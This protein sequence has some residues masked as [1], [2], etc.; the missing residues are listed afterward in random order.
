MRGSLEKPFLVKSVSPDL[1]PKTSNCFTL[2]VSTLSPTLR[3]AVGRL[4]LPTLARGLP[5]GVIQRRKSIND[6]DGGLKFFPIF[7]PRIKNFNPPVGASPPPVIPLAIRSGI[8]R[9]PLVRPSALSV[10]GKRFF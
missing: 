7:T 4:R 9:P 6:L 1:F 5:G 3:V 2:D 10:L 8:L